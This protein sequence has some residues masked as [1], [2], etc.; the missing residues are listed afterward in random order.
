MV[1]FAQG[2][3][4]SQNIIQGRLAGIGEGGELL[5]IPEGEK[6]PWPFFTGELLVY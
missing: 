3:A 1:C 4:D 2:A 5:L 6:E